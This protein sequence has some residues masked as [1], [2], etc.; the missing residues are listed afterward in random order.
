[1]VTLDLMELE[2]T[3]NLLWLEVG[4]GGKSGFSWKRRMK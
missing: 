3:N 1:M 2:Y 4:A